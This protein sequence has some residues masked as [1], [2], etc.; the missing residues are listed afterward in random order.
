MNTNRSMRKF[1]HN[2]PIT[3]IF[4]YYD[5]GQLATL[6]LKVQ[7]VKVPNTCPSREIGCYT[8]HDA[9]KVTMI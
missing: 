7:S 8:Q 4:Y 5:S 1:K 9:I 2:L 6:M 3:R